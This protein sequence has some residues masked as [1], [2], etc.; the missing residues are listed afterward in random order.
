MVKTK[1]RGEK[2]GG[3][4]LNDWLP[5][6]LI[7]EDFRLLSQMGNCFDNKGCNE[8]MSVLAML[9][10]FCHSVPRTLLLFQV[11]KCECEGAAGWH[12]A[13]TQPQRRGRV[14]SKRQRQES[15]F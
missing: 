7:T 13:L 2:D 9:L 14:D 15:E 12:S 5:L 11:I 10:P 3:H 4:A 8:C 1:Q 6:K